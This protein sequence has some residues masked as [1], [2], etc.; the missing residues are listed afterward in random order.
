MLFQ[1]RKWIFG[2]PVTIWYSKDITWNEEI[3]EVKSRHGVL[4]SNFSLWYSTSK[5]N[6]SDKIQMFHGHL[7]PFCRNCIAWASR[8]IPACVLVFPLAVKTPGLF[9][10]LF[11]SKEKIVADWYTFQST[12]LQQQF[13]NQ[14]SNWIT[15]LRIHNVTI[16]NGNVDEIEKHPQTKS[17]FAFTI[18]LI[19]I[20]FLIE[21]I[22]T[23]HAYAL[24]ILIIFGH[25]TGVFVVKPL[26][27]L[28]TFDV[29][30]IPS[31]F[32]ANKRSGL[33]SNRL[34]QMAFSENWKSESPLTIFLSSLSF[35]IYF[36]FDLTVPIA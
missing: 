3:R 26:V 24:Y 10:C 36:W 32:V 22:N 16:H 33:L 21:N 18:Q 19:S 13:W 11:C 20:R 35:G 1:R 23:T 34:Q 25:H 14:A 31:L 27:C 8:W 30:S 9:A 15:K 17:E 12:I 6:R 28:S 5:D 7:L 4:E 2:S 29:P